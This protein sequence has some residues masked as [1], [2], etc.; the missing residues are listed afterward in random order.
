MTALHHNVR[1]LTGQR[2][3]RWIDHQTQRVRGVLCRPHNFM[4]GFAKDDPEILQRAAAYLRA[5]HAAA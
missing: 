4:L 3:G 2:F 5:A 1:D